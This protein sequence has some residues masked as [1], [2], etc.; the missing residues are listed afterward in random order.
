ETRLELG[1][2]YEG[3][4]E[5]DWDVD[6]AVLEAA[7]L[8]LAE[9]WQRELR[10]RILEINAELETM[11][12]DRGAPAEAAELLDRLW[13]LVREEWTIHFL[14]V[15]P[16]LTAAEHAAPRQLLGIE[17]PADEGVSEPVEGARGGTLA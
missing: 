16:A 6:R 11:R 2:A 15:L 4:L 7:A 1:W 5:P 13:E 8:E 17:N 10:P 3:E 14:V 9:R 12:P